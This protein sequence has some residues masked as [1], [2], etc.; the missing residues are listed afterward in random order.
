[1]FYADHIGLDYIYEKVT[2]YYEEYGDW[3]RPSEL[4]RS[5]AKAGKRFV[6]HNNI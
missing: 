5:L 1:M 3:L 6:D 4:L 2:Q